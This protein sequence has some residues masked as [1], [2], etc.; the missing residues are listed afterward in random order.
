MSDGGGTRRDGAPSRRCR[1]AAYPDGPYLVRGDFD[2]H[3]GSGRVIRVRRRTVALC[4]CGRSR[5]NPFC[6]GTHKTIGFSVAGRAA[7]STSAGD[8]TEDAGRVVPPDRRG[9]GDGG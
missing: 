2:L 9:D 6:D 7:P 3:D 1:I 5:T 8:H 4:R